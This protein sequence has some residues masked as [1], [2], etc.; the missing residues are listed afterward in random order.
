MLEL[1]GA[2]FTTG[3]LTYFD[4]DPDR[5]RPHASIYV[6]GAIPLPDGASVTVLAFVDTGAPYFIVGPDIID[7]LSLR[8]LAATARIVLST[9]FGQ[10]EGFLDTV[11]LEIPAEE[12]DSLRFSVTVFAAETWTAGA[13]LGYEGCIANI[14]FAVQPR[15]NRLFFGPPDGADTALP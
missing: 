10:I 8:P 6:P 5:R 2:P 9:R 14:N 13:F 3:A 12:G 1:A 7:A 15:L 11:D 4:E